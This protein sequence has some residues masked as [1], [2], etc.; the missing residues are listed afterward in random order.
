ML[1]WRWAAAVLF[2]VSAYAQAP[3][4]ELFASDLGSPSVSQPVGTGMAVASGS[5]L[6]AGIAPSTLRLA[7]GGQVR[8]CPR[9]H[10]SVSSGGQG[11]M[12]GMGAGAIEINYRL[13]EGAADTLVTP[14]FNVRLAGPGTY[15]FAIGVTSQ[16]DTCFKPLPGNT[17]GIVFS[18]LLGSDMY[19]AAADESV[20]FP[21]GKLAGRTILTA[22][23]GCPAPPPVTTADATPEPPPSHSDSVTPAREPAASS[24]PPPQPSSEQP[25]P[26]QVQ[27][28]TPFVFSGATASAV[29]APVA[30]IDFASLPNVAFTQ[31]EAEP[32]IIAAAKPLAVRPATAKP[33]ANPAAASPNPPSSPVQET[34]NQPALTPAPG[35]KPEEKKEKKGFL[36]RLGGFFGSIFGRHSK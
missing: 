33:A 29:P 1:L 9:S 30:K 15:R 32:V 23:C 10:L 26:A 17:S 6:A 13:S 21:A 2:C 22:S 36:A 5:E 3:V 28:N 31:E 12:L 18:E 4:G 8:I 25:R 14:D 24:E 7:R 19:G 27:V 20:V 35:P 11:L 16:G 34:K